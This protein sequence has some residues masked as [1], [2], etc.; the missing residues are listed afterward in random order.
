MVRLARTEGLLLDP[1]H[2]AP[3]FAG[4]LAALRD[5]PARFG[6]TCFVHTGGIFGLFPF[7]DALR[8]MLEPGGSA[9]GW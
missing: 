4:L 8:P 9:G 5:S 3:A 7:R 6:R 1:V 2:T